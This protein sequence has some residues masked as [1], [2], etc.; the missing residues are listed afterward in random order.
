MTIDSNKLY[1]EVK[2]LTSNFSFYQK[3][4]AD[5]KQNLL[6]KVTLGI[7]NKQLEGKVPLDYKGYLGYMTTSIKNEI[8]GELNK[9]KS[10]LATMNKSYMEDMTGFDIPYVETTTSYSKLHKAIKQLNPIDKAV[11][12]WMMRGWMVKDVAN[13]LQM[14]TGTIHHHL[15]RIKEQL[16]VL[17]IEQD[18]T[19]THDSLQ[20]GHQ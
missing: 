19:P 20:E 1:N 14:P 13:A 9:R 11:I 17:L 15:N 2:K 7:Y 10:K 6:T 16:R 18:E 3:L 12:R 4:D 8:Y 5:E